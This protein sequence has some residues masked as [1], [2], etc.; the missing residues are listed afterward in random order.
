MGYEYLFPYE[1]V[2]ANSDIVIYGA[3]KLG[4]EY[5]TQIQITNYCRI[6]GF[7]D[8]NYREFEGS[9]IP[10]YSPEDIGRISFDYVVLAIRIPIAFNEIKKN[11]LK[12]GVPEEKIIVVYQ[13]KYEF[14]RLLKYDG[15][16]GNTC[17]SS[18][19]DKNEIAIYLVGGYGDHVIQKRFVSEITKC[20]PT[21]LIDLYCIRYAEFIADLYAD[22]KNIKQVICDIGGKYDANKDNYILAFTI[23]AC[24]YI[25]ID[26]LKVDELRSYDMAFF[27]KMIQ[28]QQRTEAEGESINMPV[29]LSLSRRLFK[30]YNA[31]SGFN[32]DGVFEIKDN[33][34][35]IPL[36][37]DEKSTFE[38]M[39]KQWG[40][41]IY[42][43]MNCGNGECSDNDLVAK[44]WPIENYEILVKLIKHK[45][46]YIY[47]IQLGGKD[48]NR[49][50][51]CDDFIIGKKMSVAE[52]VLA[53]SLL[54]IDT[55]GGL[56]HIASQLGTKC[57]VLFGPTSIDYYGYES[58][59]N[60]TAGNC[61]NC[62]GLYLD[63]NKCARGLNKPECMYSISPQ[64]VFA[65][66]QEYLDKN[67]M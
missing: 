26:T 65:F 17:I 29:Y 51:G 13:R 27:E 25:S 35:S 60:I 3:G 53:H 49:I 24:H 37:E 23:E 32:Y 5:Y 48:A 59:I 61:H 55:E 31:Y 33:A 39:S 62:W 56:V 16:N 66:T 41:K 15:S 20:V 18:V 63:I 21:C 42:I 50:N 34:V 47:I 1:R 14:Q 30:G 36:K 67:V 45:Y 6:V 52:H 38:E 7:I 43:T 12:H 40:N 58:N 19:D 64:M 28:L 9:I 11:L 44:T 8:R 22:I 10:V 54:H 4:Q 57:I 46:P 2:K